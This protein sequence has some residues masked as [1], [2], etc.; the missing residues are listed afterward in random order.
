MESSV[1]MLN[2]P[3]NLRSGKGTVTS[4]VIFAAT[5]D[6][7]NIL[8]ELGVAACGWQVSL[9]SCSPRFAEV[10]LYYAIFVAKFKAK[11]TKS[12]EGTAVEPDTLSQSSEYEHVL[13]EREV[14]FARHCACA[15]QSFLLAGVPPVT[16]AGV[17]RQ[18]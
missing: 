3:S 8:R 18:Y 6:L 9:S 17:G 5:L 12:I 2:M 1:E 11:L 4:A 14:D 16:C 15:I 7:G 13:V 10:H